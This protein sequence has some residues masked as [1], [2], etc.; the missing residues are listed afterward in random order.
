V[1]REMAGA[2]IARISEARQTAPKPF[3]LVPPGTT[4][5]LSRLT[6]DTTPL[7]RIG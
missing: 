5:I 7:P 4:P 6:P 2:A 1:S 3:N